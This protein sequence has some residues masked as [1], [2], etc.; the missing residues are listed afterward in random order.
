MKIFTTIFF[1]LFLTGLKLFGQSDY[2]QLKQKFLTADSIIAISYGSNA[3]S[4][5]GLEFLLKNE[6]LS[7]YS[8]RAKQQLDH[9]QI[10]QLINI[11]TSGDRILGRKATTKYFKPRNAILIYKDSVLSYIDICF[12]CQRIETT[13]DIHFDDFD[14]KPDKWTKIKQYFKNLNLIDN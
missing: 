3:D 9:T 12:T 5:Q 4:I 10:S 13:D 7:L 8:L 2:S 11:L 6:Y 14:I 1:F